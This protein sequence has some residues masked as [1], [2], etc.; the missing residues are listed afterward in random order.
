MNEDEVG[1]AELVAAEAGVEVPKTDTEQTQTTET[2]STEAGQQTTE[3]QTTQGTTDDQ[4]TQAPSQD[5]QQVAQNT[6]T[7]TE[8]D[9]NSQTT[10]PR[11]DWSKFLPPVQE[12]PKP[13]ADENGQVDSG[14]LMDYMANEVVNRIRQENQIVTQVNEGLSKAEEILPEMKTDPNIARLV[15]DATFA[16]VAEGQQPDFVKTAEAFK[17]VL[18]SARAAANTNAQVGFTT[19]QNAQVATGASNTKE[20]VS[21]GAKLADRINAN[22]QDAFVELLDVWQQQGVV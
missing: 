12:L 11:V 7:Q 17:E 3:Q 1:M 21:N 15:R 13:Q 6:E 18:G 14:E 2:Q 19:Q 16:S 8:T 5:D 20:E 10:E 9:T 22:D 4:S